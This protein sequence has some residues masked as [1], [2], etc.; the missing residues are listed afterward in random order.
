[1]FC[2]NCGNSI[3]S[4][5]VFCAFCGTPSAAGPGGHASLQNGAKLLR[6]TAR[7]FLGL[8][9][10]NILAGIILTIFGWIPAILCVVVG[11]VE[12]INARIY[13]S[14][15]PT[16]SSC[17]TYVSI[18]EIVSGLVGSLWSVVGGVANL[19]RLRSPEVKAYLAALQ[20]GVAVPAEV[21]VGLPQEQIKR[22]PRCAETIRLEALVCHF[23]SHQ[24]NEAEVKLAQE[25]AQMHLASLQ[26]EALRA[27]RP[28][29]PYAGFWRRLAALLIDTAILAVLW[30]LTF[31]IFIL[32]F[33][34][35]T[36]TQPSEAI[37]GPVLGLL[38]VTFFCLYFPLFESSKKQ[39]TLGKMALGVA[40]T[41][42][43]GKRISFWRALARTLAK[44][45]SGLP[46]YLGYLLAAFTE[47][48]QAL[49]D[50]I[51]STLVVLKGGNQP[52]PFQASGFSI[53]ARPP[54]V[55]NSMAPAV[56]RSASAATGSAGQQPT[57]T[58]ARQPDCIGVRFDIGKIGS[59]GYGEECWKVFWRA[60]STEIVAGAQLLDGDTNDTPD[61][62][63]VYCLAIK[64]L[65][66]SGR[67]DDVRKALERSDDYR[68]VASIPNFLA[69]AQ[70]SREPL[71]QDGR[72]DQSGCITGTSYR[73]L[74][75]LKK[76]LEERAACVSVAEAPPAA[77]AAPAAGAAGL[78]EAAR[79]SLYEE[80]KTA[81][82]SEIK[83]AQEKV[84]S[85]IRVAPG[86]DPYYLMGF[87][88]QQ[89]AKSSRPKEIREACLLQIA[90]KFKLS[91]PEIE[92]IVFQGEKEKW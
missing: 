19:M 77:S 92:A 42:L 15:P 27:Q 58:A 69:A 17:P 81:Y 7:T 18:L 8:G 29:S 30:F 34:I 4:G 25:Q 33:H 46:F 28:R 86:Q 43:D 38:L 12:L 53:P 35:F 21:A 23:C 6:A 79:R 44:I 50:L 80:F 9:I 54:S 63:N 74:P 37:T 16:S 41:G 49:H 5:A 13:W 48:K 75:A 70:V 87:A 78:D 91:L 68:K 90:S 60:V 62:E 59:G 47:K 40:V 22:C 83:K 65:P 56:T 67:G 31:A 36:H 24:F 61:R 88:F 73:A 26:L 45:L 52:A 39:A 76:V 10:V 51:A 72:V 89:F 14:T 32:M 11:I 3:P 2:G 57:T 82:A 20:A 64:W 1:M 66:G 71:V 84:M 55:D 85:N